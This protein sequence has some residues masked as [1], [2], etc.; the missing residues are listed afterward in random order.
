MKRKNDRTSYMSSHSA[1]LAFDENQ[2]AT[3]KTDRV[4][5]V[6]ALIFSDTNVKHRASIGTG[7]RGG[8]Q[9]VKYLEVWLPSM[10][11]FCPLTSV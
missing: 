9:A 10:R 3:G 5:Y 8:G 11:A 2:N 1:K 7:G 6:S 4:I